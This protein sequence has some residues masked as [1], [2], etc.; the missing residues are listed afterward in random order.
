MKNTLF[1]ALALCT[2]IVAF[3]Q[4]PANKKIA[5]L[6]PHLVGGTVTAIQKSMIRATLA[7]AISDAGMFDALTRTDI[8]QLTKE[9]SFQRSGM[10]DDDERQQIGKMSG[11]DLI[12]LSLVTV[13]N[14]DLFIEVQ[15]IEVESGRIFKTAN[16]LMQISSNVGLQTGCQK[17]ANKL[18]GESPTR[19]S[20]EQRLNAKDYRKK[21]DSFFLR[22]HNQYIAFGILNT[23]YPVTMGTSLVGRYGGIMGIGVY[24]TIGLDFAGKSTY[25]PEKSSYYPVEAHRKFIA[26]LHYSAGL[27]LFPYK[28]AFLS[29]GYGTLG[30]EKKKMSSGS[31]GHW[32]T[33]GWRQG[34]GLVLGGGYDI[35]GNLNNT[36]VFFSPSV[37]LSFDTFT[38]KWQPLF[39][40]K[41][42]IAWGYKE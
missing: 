31:N 23:G 16:E 17:L 9:M 38:D 30:C 36:G 20:A 6:E 28:N 40:V 19:T 39:N 14:N 35:L 41:L 21:N 24:L 4:E 11:A 25:D 3:G 27:K 15:L 34:K 1:F 2:T 26:P 8:D 29:I 37:G 10:V 32:N 18:L 42:G 22:G 33:T 5:M 13:E 7:K 12:C